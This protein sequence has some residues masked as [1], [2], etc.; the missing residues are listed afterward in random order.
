[1]VTV[2]L[3]TLSSPARASDPAVQVAVVVGSGVS[4]SG[5]RPLRYADD[6]AVASVE[7]FA[8]LGVKAF[9]LVDPDDETAELH[10][11]AALAARRAVTRPALEGALDQAFAALSEAHRAGRRTR[12]YFVFAG[13]GD[14]AGGRPFLQLGPHRIFRD[15][16]AL[17]LRRSPAD[18]NHVI[19]DACQASLFVSAR[20]PGGARAAITP[21]F[22]RT[23]DAAWPRHTGLLTARSAG[24]LTHEWTEF[25]AGIFSHEIR[26][27][28]LG[29]ADVDG[30]GLVTYR[31]LGAFVRRANEAI[32]NRKYRPEVITLAPEGNLDAVVA[33]LPDGPLLLDLGAN[34][35]RAFVETQRG[36]RLLD[37]HPDRG[38]PIRVRLPTHRG[39][40]FVQRLT[41]ETEFLIDPRPGQV[42]LA[43]LAGRPSRLRARGAAHEAFLALFARP[44]DRAAV[45]TFR[46]D[47]D[48]QAGAADVSA[49]RLRPWWPFAL[50]ATGVAAN[51]AGL[52]LGLQGHRLA[53]Q[54]NDGVEAQRLGPQ[55]S[56]YNRAAVITG[57]VGVSLTGLGLGWMWWTRDADRNGGGSDDDR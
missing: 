21:G 27:G 47:L 54:A 41:D 15:D 12:F 4:P 33:E 50:T 14:L 40:L 24:G 48:L 7:T 20:G 28:L 5:G 45:A 16:L 57:A 3:L 8:L 35:G 30:N 42:R 55:V 44:L 49:S 56:R 26:S 6:D 46:A 51:L 19:I 38:L 32:V 37:V 34:V 2:L 53:R 43:G 11:P 29:G 31:E 25:Q 52:G 36:V 9:L 13:H 23:A 22:S 39:P 1:M 18:D 10:P 17:L